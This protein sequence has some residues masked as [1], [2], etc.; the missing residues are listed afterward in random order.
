VKIF[1]LYFTRLETLA[2]TL[3]ILFFA[4]LFF[5]LHQVAYATSSFSETNGTRSLF[6]NNNNTTNVP[7]VLRWSLSPSGN[8]TTSAELPGNGKSDQLAGTGPYKADHTHHSSEMNLGTSDH[9]DDSSNS[10]SLA[11]KII[12]KI[13]QK[14][15]AG[16]VPFP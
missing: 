3:I 11:Q 5:S 8:T 2:V 4:C 7:S 15:K 1:G 12:K 6:K 13:K 9:H 10:I 16:D 14:F